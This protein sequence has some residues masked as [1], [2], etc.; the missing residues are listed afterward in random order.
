MA[1]G[2]RRAGA[3]GAV[4]FVNSFV[5]RPGN[6]GARTAHVLAA[7]AEAGGCGACV[8][9]GA[10][11][12]TPGVRYLEMGWL[13]HLP[14]ALNALRIYL[15]PGY[16]HRPHDIALFE[17]FARRQLG[18]LAADGEGAPVAHVWE[19][20]PR[21][22]E[23]LRAE[24]WRVVLD[25]PIAPSSYA[26]RI[27]GRHG[28]S[29]LQV[30]PRIDRMER[31]AH[32]LAHVIVVP[33]PFVA[34]TLTDAGVD[35]AKLRVVEFGVDLPPAPPPRPGAARTAGLDF[36][37]VGN[38]NRRKG[39]AEL[40]GAWSTGGFA[41]DRLHLC[42]RVYPEVRADLAGVGGGEVIAPG[43]VRP[44]AYL[45]GCDVFVFPSWLEGSAKAVFEAMACGLPVITTPSAGSVV[46]DGREGFVVPAGDVA[47]LRE[48]M[49]WLRAHPEARRRMGEAARARAAEFPWSRYARRVLEV[50]SEQAACG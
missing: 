15:A 3:P 20:A 31:R 13:G 41:G 14:R 2:A 36:C 27:T 34:E 47:A 23:R 44:Y 5:G 10:A 16:N 29:F 26:M 33:S 35:P 28:L 38:V 45:P 49:L 46:R 4:Q 39:I 8:C 12:R 19:V 17:W 1:E 43:F 25:V 37:F 32:E 42:G 7:L 11:V 40:L 22:L 18:R 30:D 6:I 21:L 24:G 48:R 9:R 50:Y